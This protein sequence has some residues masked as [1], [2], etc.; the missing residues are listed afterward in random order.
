MGAIPPEATAPEAIPAEIA[1]PMIWRPRWKA[2]S[3]MWNMN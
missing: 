2:S 3:S 1:G